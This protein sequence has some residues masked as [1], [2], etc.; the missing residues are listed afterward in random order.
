MPARGQL[1]LGH[2]VRKLDQPLDSL[3]HLL[4]L[5]YVQL[6]DLHHWLLKVLVA[7]NF[8]NLSV[9]KLLSG[10]LHWRLRKDFC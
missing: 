4:Q 9:I 1:R 7:G 10:L 6:G 2:H 8:I 5:V 3:I